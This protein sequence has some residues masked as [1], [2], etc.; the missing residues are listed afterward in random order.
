MCARRAIRIPP[1]NRAGGICR[2]M[3]EAILVFGFGKMGVQAQVEP[4]RQIGGLAHQRGGDGKRRAGGERDLHHRAFAAL[5]MTLHHALAIGED[6]VLVLHD[7]IRRQPAVALR[8][9]HR[10]SGQ[11]YAHAQTARGGD[12]D[13]DGVF[14]P[15][16]KDVMMIRCHCRA[17]QQQLGRRQRRREV[18]RFRRQTRPE[19]I[20]RL[21]PGKQFT[22]E[23]RGHGARER[24]IKMVMGVDQ[25]GQHHVRGGVECRYIRRCRRAPGRDQLYDA[26]VHN[27]DAARRTVRENRQRVF[28]PEGRRF[29]I[30]SD[31][32]RLDERNY[33]PAVSPAEFDGLRG[34]FIGWQICGVPVWLRRRVAFVA[35]QAVRAAAYIAGRNAL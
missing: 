3:A 29:G 15:F 13:V 34:A 24:L 33:Q 10:P 11:Q 4:S 21:Q 25:P 5:V 22:V 26:A 1:G 18:K 16:G 9:I 23:R 6:R 8:Q 31:A 12:F 28:D 32:R 35:P 20:E 19:R 7:R 2:A 30:H 27:H 17:R 14:E